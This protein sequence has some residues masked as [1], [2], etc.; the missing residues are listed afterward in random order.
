MPPPAAP[1]KPVTAPVAPPAAAAP[2]PSVIPPPQPQTA[3]QALF[4]QA[5][6]AVQVDVGHDQSDPLAGGRPANLP[7]AVPWESGHV[8]QP[9]RTPTQPAEYVT[10]N[11]L[12]DPAIMAHRGMLADEERRLAALRAKSPVVPIPDTTPLPYSH[13]TAT[14]KRSI[15]VRH[16]VDPLLVEA[17]NVLSI[18]VAGGLIAPAYDKSRVL[19]CLQ[20]MEKA[21]EYVPAVV[22]PAPGDEKKS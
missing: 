12:D 18:L 13:L 7:A 6:R 19:A 17:Y 3:Q 21:I 16:D 4:D 1:T 8:Q 20:K 14:Q 15:V 10:T 11:P 22:A 9:S 5:M 2:A